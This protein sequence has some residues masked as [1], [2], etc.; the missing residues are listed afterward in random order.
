VLEI[1][2]FPLGAIHPTSG[3]LDWFFSCCGLGAGWLGE[4]RLL[5]ELVARDAQPCPVGWEYCGVRAN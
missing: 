4:R 3:F 2:S 5:L 1:D